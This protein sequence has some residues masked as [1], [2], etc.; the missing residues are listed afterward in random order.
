MKFTSLLKKIGQAANA[1][2][3]FIPVYGPLVHA[4]TS[5][6]SAKTDEK[7]TSAIQATSDGLHQ[8]EALVVHA[9][10]MGQAI[11]APGS[12]RAAMLAPAAFQLL[13]DGLTVCRG[14]KPRDADSARV[15]A[16]AVGAAVADFLN[17]FE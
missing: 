2:D 3:Q 17:E 12:Q 14:K 9:E 7:A 6:I 15:K 11:S 4:V 5:S 13:M 1:A 10:A 16:A 8:L